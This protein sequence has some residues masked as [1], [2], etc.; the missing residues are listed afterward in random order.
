[1]TL[2]FVEH[3]DPML[4]DFYLFTDESEPNL[5][6]SFLCFLMERKTLYLGEYKHESRIQVKTQY[7]KNLIPMDEFPADEMF[8]DVNMYKRFILTM[9]LILKNM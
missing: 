5:Y 3:S 6:N 1:M 7:V 9:R 4:R 8:G 2:Y